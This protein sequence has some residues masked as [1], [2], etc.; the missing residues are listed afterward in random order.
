[1][2]NP[3]QKK[4]IK[5]P[6]NLSNNERKVLG[7]LIVDYIK[8]RSKKGLDSQNRPFKKYDETYLRHP[9]FKLADKTKK[10]NLSFTGEMLD[11]LE[12]LSHTKGSLTIGYEAGS[13]TNDK[14]FYN[15]EEHKRDFLGITQEDVNRIANKLPETDEKP[16]IEIASF[17][18]AILEGLKKKNES[19]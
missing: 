5:I 8:E 2:S 13:T 14:A 7:E 15:I 3:Q 1:M 16:I 9:D 19:K 18:K 11:D 12:V 6:K 10:V 4:K 17:T